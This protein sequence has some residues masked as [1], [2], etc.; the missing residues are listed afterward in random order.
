MA[1]RRPRRRH[2]PLCQR[3]FFFCH[4]HMP[5]SAQS[6]CFPADSIRPRPAAIAERRVSFYALSVDYGQ[7]HRLEL[8]AARRVAAAGHAAACDVSVDL[9][10]IGG[11]G[12]PA[13]IDVPRDRA[14]RRWP[15]NSGDLCSGPQHGVPVAG[16]GLCGGAAGRPIFSWASTPSTT[17]AIP[18][19]GRSSSRPSSGWPIWPPRP[20]SK[21]AEFQIHTPLIQLTKAE[22][23]RRGV[24]W[25]WTT[26]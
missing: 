23:I 11:S 3:A 10:A 4:A 24:D 26:A 7:R 14:P 2:W 13:E 6:S 20:A 17:A 15:R 21:G 16:L 1:D 18:I 25:A 5:K 9:G 12:L 8:E 22:I 19:A